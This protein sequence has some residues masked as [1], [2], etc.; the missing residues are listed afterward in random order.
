MKSSE[1]RNR[2]VKFFESKGHDIVPS[3]SLVPY[4]DPTLL[5]INAGMAPL[6][7][8]FDGSELPKNPRMT[9]SQKCI[10]T[11]DIENVGKTARHHTMFEMLGNFSIGD[12]FKKDAIHWAWEF[13]TEELKFDKS[14]LY[15]TIH[16]EDDE[17]FD[18]WTKEIGMPEDHIARTKEDNF[19]DIGEGP[20]GPCSEIF[21]DRKPELGPDETFH[22]DN[23]GETRYLEVWN[24]VFTQFNH[25]AD[26][27]YTELPK[28]NIDTGAGLERLVSLIQGGE[29]NFDTDLFL[30]IIEE[31]ARLSGQ[32]YHA[33]PDVDIAFKVIADHIRTVTFSVGDGALP[34]NE[35][36]GY[37]IRRLL[38]RAVRYGKVL[39]IEK[40]FMFSLVK[41]VGDI[42]GEFYPEVLQ[43]REFIERVVKAEEERFHVT[44]ADGETLLA[45]VLGRVKGAGANILPGEEAFRLYDT[46]GFPIDLTEDICAEQGIEIDRAG[47][48]KA[49]N[50]QRQRA[51]AA[52]KDVTSMAVQTDLYNELDI[53]SN[54]VGYS[55]T[56]TAAQVLAII[57]GEGIV[58]E[59]HE[60]EEVALF[61]SQT[62]FYAESGG[63][64]GDIGLIHVG[65]SAI[66][67]VL[68]VQKAPNGYNLHKARVLS[69]TVKVLDE[70]E[71]SIDYER[72]VAIT[73][74][75]T[76]THLLH[77]ALRDVLGEHVAQAGSLVGPERLRFD[78]SHLSGMNADEIAEVE[79]RVNEQ[80]WANEVVDINEMSIDDAK[81]LGA[82]A[83]FG[84]KYGD[85]VRVVRAG[86]YSIELCGG[87]H[88]RSTGEIGLFKILTESSIAAGV[89]R[90]EAV[91]G[92]GAYEFVAERERLLQ[93]VA[94]KLKSNIT[95]IPM[96]VDILQGNIKDLGKE[97]ESLKSKL[98]MGEVK[99]LVEQIRDVDGVP[100]LAAKLEGVDM[101]GLRA[102]A[103]DL[104]ARLDSGVIVLGAAQGADKV[105]FVVAVTKDLNAKGIQAGKLVKEVASITGGGGGG[106]PD[107]AQAGGKDV[108]KLQ[109]ALDKA[110]EL[111]QGMLV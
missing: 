70:A 68:D 3:A 30:P 72:R 53:S 86:D 47:F 81:K 67:Q 59:A 104:K 57:T 103:E 76:A 92:K 6:K 85:V 23:H 24:L 95:D 77:K 71:A 54:F 106:R 65:A 60:G 2:F 15:C 16:V 62:P 100:F 52:R 17:A 99:N 12:Y 50:E 20:C 66:V 90:V 26:G 7:K 13:L 29:T 56:A 93:D 5:W 22:P 109:E 73:R 84:E 96:R 46:Y 40:P 101:D 35:G 80:I 61:L 55:E 44:L 42:M 51:R 41:I 36:R 108:T 74:N 21:F 48:E 25:N 28:K 18:I 91:T 9:N 75:H 27:T 102:I 1:I 94:G 63:Q 43:K 78:F 111:L 4:N 45:E 10:R 107:L 83:L 89:R 19:W 110:Q 8:F 105:S 88:V 37:V 64:V 58:E 32:T 31:T 11:N 87:C 14:R 49:L 69:G 33:S 79:R 34:S 82:M 38:R 39:G 97:I 98:A